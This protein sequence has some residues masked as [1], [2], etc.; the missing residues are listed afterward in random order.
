MSQD[1][2][3]EETG[4]KNSPAL[5]MMCLFWN[6]EFLALTG[7]SSSR[8]SFGTCEP[9]RKAECSNVR[10]F[11][12]MAVRLFYSTFFVGTRFS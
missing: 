12:F 8:N 9:G 3:M 4:T 6:L 1:R 5:Y 11:I 2:E 10:G 7:K